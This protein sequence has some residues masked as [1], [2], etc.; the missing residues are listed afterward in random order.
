MQAVRDFLFGL[1]PWNWFILSV[2]LFVMETIIPGV[3]FLWFGIAATCVG[4]LGLATGFSWE[5]QVIAFGLISMSTVFVINRM[6]KSE[7]SESEQPDLNLRGQQ[8]IGRTV[9]V[10]Q[11]ISSGRGKV[12][13]GDTIWTAEGPDL[14][15]GARARITGARGTILLVEAA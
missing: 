8:Y 1:G 6:F 15:R 2:L 4:I 14:P 7:E 13:V 9:V 12:K 10:E 5:W 3:H 11:A